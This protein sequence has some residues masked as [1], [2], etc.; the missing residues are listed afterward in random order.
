MASRG[1]GKWIAVALY[2]LL[3][4]LLLGFLILYAFSIVPL[5]SDMFTRFLISLLVVVLLLPSIPRI[6]IFDLVEV[7]RKAQMFKKK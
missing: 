3:V 7:T 1:R 2:L 5:Q 6:K 4:A